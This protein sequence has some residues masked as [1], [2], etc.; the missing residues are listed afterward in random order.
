[1]PGVI[2]EHLLMGSVLH[3]LDEDLLKHL[4]VRVL[5]DAE[6]PRKRT[7]HAQI[8]PEPT[9]DVTSVDLDYYSSKGDSDADDSGDDGGM[10]AFRKVVATANEVIRRASA[11]RKTVF[12]FC[13]HG[14]NESAVVCMAY[15]MVV[16]QWTLERSYRHVLQKR[17]ASAPRKAYIEKVSPIHRVIMP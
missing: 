14:N 15:L 17:P 11:E 2:A 16:E 7:A 5:L 12:V 9:I 13:T 3:A 6:N 8:A 10:D 1:V 4:Q